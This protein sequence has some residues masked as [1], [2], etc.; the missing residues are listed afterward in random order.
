M[1]ALGHKQTFALQKVA[2]KWMSAKGHKLT[3]CHVTIDSLR[4][5]TPLLQGDIVAQQDKRGNRWSDIHPK[6]GIGIPDM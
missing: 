1:S 2:P 5:G 3:F 4:A 6:V